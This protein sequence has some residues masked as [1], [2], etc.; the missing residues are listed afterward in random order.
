MKQKHLTAIV[1]T[2]RLIIDHSGIKQKHLEVNPKHSGVNPKH[3]AVNPKNS[4]KHIHQVS[5]VLSCTLLLYAV[6]TLFH[7][8]Y[9]HL[10]PQRE[11]A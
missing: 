6:W 8:N 1:K 5:K 9:R 10:I 11:I 3:L 2:L 7:L 4:P